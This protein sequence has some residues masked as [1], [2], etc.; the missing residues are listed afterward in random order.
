MDRKESLGHSRQKRFVFTFK[1]KSLSS[2][3]SKPDIVL[4]SS[5]DN[6]TKKKLKVI[7]KNKKANMSRK[8]RKPISVKNN[9]SK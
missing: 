9:F 5:G 4:I 3:G 6:L 2:L 8:F 7:L 1:T